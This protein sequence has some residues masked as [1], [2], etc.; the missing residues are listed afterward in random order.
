M[1]D[2]CTLFLDAFL[3]FLVLQITCGSNLLSIKKGDLFF[4]ETMGYN[5][6]YSMQEKDE[7]GQLT[8]VPALGVPQNL[9]FF[10]KK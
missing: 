7:S 2:I 10:R 1:V 3:I 6:D 9:K 4:G 5:H 8:G